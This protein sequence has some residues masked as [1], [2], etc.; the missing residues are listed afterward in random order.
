MTDQPL[1]LLLPLLFGLPVDK[2]WETPSSEPSPSRQE[3][4]AERILE[5]VKEQA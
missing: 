2:S 3:V 5:L 1:Q 4:V